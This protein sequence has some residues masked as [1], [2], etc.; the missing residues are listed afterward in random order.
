MRKFKPGQAVVFEP[1]WAREPV[2]GGLVYPEHPLRYGSIV[3][4]LAYITPAVGHCIVTTY[5]GQV[6]TMLHP[7]D[8]RAAR[9]DEV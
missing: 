2:S 8:F 1:T 7:T 9:E 4:F 6:L 5:E 3:L